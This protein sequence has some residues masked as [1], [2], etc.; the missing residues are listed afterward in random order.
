M[1]PVVGKMLP[2]SMLE[3]DVLEQTWQDGATW[4]SY[5]PGTSMAKS[6][7]KIK[8]AAEA[9]G[10]FVV[11]DVHNPHITIDP[12]TLHKGGKVIIIGALQRGAN[13]EPTVPSPMYNA[14]FKLLSA[15]A[16]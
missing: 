13:G 6:V 15:E 14:L 7:A 10:A 11:A 3:Q 1:F 2:L 4:L 12:L 16:A 8:A 9:S 5:E